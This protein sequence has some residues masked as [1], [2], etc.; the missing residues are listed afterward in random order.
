MEATNGVSQGSNLGP[1]LFDLYIND[2]P[3]YLKD[4]GYNYVC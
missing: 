4:R 2:L 3:V 1:L